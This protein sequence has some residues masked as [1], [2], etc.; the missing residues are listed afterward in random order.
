MENTAIREKLIQALLRSDE[1]TRIAR[2]E[3]IEWAS[4]H[5]SRPSA[6][7]GPVDTLRLIEEARVCFVSGH[8][9][10]TLL[11]VTSFVEHTLA[12]ELN[13]LGLSNGNPTLGRMISL[14]RDHLSLPGDLLDRAD[15]L[16]KLR[17]PFV[18]RRPETDPDTL[19]NRFLSAKVHPDTIMETDAKLALDVMYELFR[20]TLRG[21]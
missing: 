16:R 1:S 5:D 18:H 4:H 10:A 19:G 8:F 15:S 13:E 6:Y 9:L 11:L 14:A 20:L 3:R 2:A 21:A 17:N 7:A 12:D